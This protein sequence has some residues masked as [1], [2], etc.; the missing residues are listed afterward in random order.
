MAVGLSPQAAYSSDCSVELPLRPSASAAPPSGPRSLRRRLR[1]RGPEAG[2]EERQ[3]ALTQKRTLWSRF[4]EYGAAYDSDCSVE[5][6]LRPAASAAPP[7]GPRLLRSSLW[8]QKVF[9][10]MSAG[11]DTKANAP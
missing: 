4:E 5:L 6:P 11:A 9:A 2:G 8:A 1:G 10:F 7:F 3:R